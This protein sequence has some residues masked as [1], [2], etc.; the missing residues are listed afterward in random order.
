VSQVLAASTRLT[1]S[2]Q[3]DPDF[4]AL[5]MVTTAMVFASFVSHNFLQRVSGQLPGVG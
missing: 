5:T 3:I 4:V 1:I 2:P